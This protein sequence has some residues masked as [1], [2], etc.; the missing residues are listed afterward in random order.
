MMP[1]PTTGDAAA[2][3]RAC[4]ALATNILDFTRLATDSM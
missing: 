4:Q 3:D 2:S 1:M